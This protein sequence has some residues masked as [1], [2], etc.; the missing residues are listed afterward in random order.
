MPRL[1]SGLTFLC[2]AS[3]LPLQRLMIPRDGAVIPPVPRVLRPEPTA[4]PRTQGQILLK[5]P[6]VLFGAAR[7][8]RERGQILLAPNAIPQPSAAFRQECG[9]IPQEQ[10]AIPLRNGFSLPPDHRFLWQNRPWLDRN[11]CSLSQNGPGLQRNCSFPPP[12]SIHLRRKFIRHF[13][14]RAPLLTNGHGWLRNGVSVPLGLM[15]LPPQCLSFSP[16]TPRA[17]LGGPVI[18]S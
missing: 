2:P 15:T 6:A 12:N 11:R 3:S 9:S 18:D 5:Q 10:R 14:K 7:V 13:P 4:F 8:R 16:K 1:K 17:H